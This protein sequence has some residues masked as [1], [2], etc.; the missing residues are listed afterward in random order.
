M[1]IEL[2][3]SAVQE[4]SWFIRAA[5]R[6]HFLIGFANRA[7]VLLQSAFAFDAKR[8]RGRVLDQ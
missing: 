7:F 3:E 6:I 1:G 2:S 4:V 8:R 5:V